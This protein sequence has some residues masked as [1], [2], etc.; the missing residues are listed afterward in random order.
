MKL[1]VRQTEDSAGVNMAPLID[2]VFILLIFFLVT[3]MLQKPHNELL[4]D[5]PEAGA[6]EKVTE[7]HAPLVI[8]VTTQNPDPLASDDN[9]GPRRD[10]HIVIDGEPV[11]R[12]LL[13][14]RLRQVAQETPGRRIRI[15]SEPQLKLRHVVPIVDLC[16]FHGLVRVDVRPL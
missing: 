15:D 5:V 8:K 14:R 10:P 2:C 13:E 11:T 3:S 1:R 4:L 16:R 12:Q 7:E 9:D 6:A